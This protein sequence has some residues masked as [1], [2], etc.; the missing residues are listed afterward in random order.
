M[1]W[2]GKI[3]QATPLWDSHQLGELSKQNSFEKWDMIGITRVSDMWMD[4]DVVA[5]QALLTEYKLAPGEIFKYFQIQH[6]LTA[7]LQREEVV[8]EASPL[9]MRLLGEHM[10][11]KATSF[12]YRKI[13]NN[14]PDTLRQLR[15]KW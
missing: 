14:M 10:T 9:E 11:S 1:G 3:T 8:P 5:W 2:A 12:T 6:A 15:E 13:L 4:G 7:A